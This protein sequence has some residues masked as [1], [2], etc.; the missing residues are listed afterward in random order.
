[1]A[2]NLTTQPPNV[3]GALNRILF[4]L[5]MTDGG[6]PPIEISLGYRLEDGAG[7]PITGDEEV[8][9]KATEYLFDFRK[10]IQ[11]ELRTT[12]PSLGLDTLVED[13][14]AI[15]T[16]QLKYWEK[17]FNSSDCSVSNGSE[18]TAGPYTAINAGFDY[19]PSTP[20]SGSGK[21]LSSRPPIIYACPN[22][23]D[24]LYVYTSSAITVE[25]QGFT[26]AG[27]GGPIETL[28]LD[29]DKVYIV[30]IG[31]GNAFYSSL[32]TSIYDYFEIRVGLIKTYKVL[33]KCSPAEQSATLIWLEPAGGYAS[34]QMDLVDSWS[35]SKAI[36]QVVYPRDYNPIALLAPNDAAILRQGTRIKSQSGRKI[37]MS[38]TIRWGYEGREFL[39]GLISSNNHMVPLEMNNGNKTLARFN[40]EG[41]DI[42]WLDGRE[43]AIIQLTGTLAP[44]ITAHAHE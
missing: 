41:G 14:T 19:Q 1:M 11:R 10:E 43:E 17:S 8:P 28:N 2:I 23:D 29:A 3:E 38:K 33:R 31:F 30:P 9:F 36:S 13:L 44:E 4:G 6:T 12:W 21:V 22:Q 35:V 5:T 39:E 7:N 26:N 34:L 20:F 42:T 32:I 40:L 16:Y 27:L 25:A 24:W 37:S 18:S 15:K